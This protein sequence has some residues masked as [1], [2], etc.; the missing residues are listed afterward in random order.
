MGVDGAVSGAA[1]RAGAQLDI[2]V[3]C[4]WTAIARPMGDALA[5]VK[6]SVPRPRSFAV[7]AQEGPRSRKKVHFAKLAIISNFR[8]KTPEND[9][10]LE[11]VANFYFAEKFTSWA[12]TTQSLHFRAIRRMTG[13]WSWEINSAEQATHRHLCKSRGFSDSSLR[14]ATISCRSRRGGR[15]RADL[16]LPLRT[17]RLSHCRSLPSR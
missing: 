16:L 4:L 9:Q 17:Q 5:S 11:I 8:A 15:R 7:E 3:S 12:R 14:L 2:D 1:A 6:M 10:K 13:M